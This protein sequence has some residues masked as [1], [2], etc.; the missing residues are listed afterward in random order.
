MAYALFG[1]P[2]NAVMLLGM[3]CAMAGVVLVNWRR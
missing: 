1:E 2:L 3:A